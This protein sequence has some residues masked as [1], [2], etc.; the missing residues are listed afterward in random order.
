[1]IDPPRDAAEAFDQFERLARSIADGAALVRSDGVT[2]SQARDAL[3][4]SAFRPALPGFV[5]QCLSV[6]KYREFILL[7]HPDPGARRAFVDQLLDP[8]R[9]V[10]AGLGSGADDRG[11]APAAPPTER[12]PPPRGSREWML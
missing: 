1:M 11:S 12:D 6:F 5:F 3:L 4:A 7:Y 8:A 2:W 10:R 9:R